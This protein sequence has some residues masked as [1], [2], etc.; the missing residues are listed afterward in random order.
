MPT[1]SGKYWVTWANANAKNSKKIDDLE[2]NFKSN[3]NSFIKALKAAGAT[4]SVSATKRNKKRAYLF[5]W[6]W[7]ISQ[8]KSKPSDATKLPG[9]DIEWDHGDSSKSKAGALEMVKGFGLAVPPKSV[10]PPSLTSNHISGKAIDMT[11]KWTG[12]I[13]IN[14]K[15]GTTVEVEYMSNVNKNTS[16]HSI[17]E[18]YGVKKLK[19]DAPHWSYNGR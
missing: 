13:K 19:T 9:V 12:K 7:K 6:S 8:G 3:V 11:I 1:K 10:N 18:S 2:E 5:H 4:V 17:G 16:L 14:K 15:D